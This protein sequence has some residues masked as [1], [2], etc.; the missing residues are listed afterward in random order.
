MGLPVQVCHPVGGLTSSGK[1]FIQSRALPFQVSYLSSWRPYLFRKDI[2]TVGN[3]TYIGKLFM[4][5][6]TLPLQIRFTCS[7][8]P[9]L[10]R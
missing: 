7:W 6:E 9:Y 3:L 2:H 8:G 5:S 4:Q 1:L 10:F